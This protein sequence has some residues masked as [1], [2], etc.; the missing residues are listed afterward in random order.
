MPTI[1]VAF[2]RRNSSPLVLSLLGFVVPTVVCMMLLVVLLD[3]LHHHSLLML[4]HLLILGI[5]DT[6]VSPNR[7]LFALLI[8]HS[9]SLVLFS[10]PLALLHLIFKITLV[11]DFK[12]SHS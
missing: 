11:Q 12:Q 1:V 7:P 6:F 2:V 3:L 9:V 4:L 8:L 10:F 5:V